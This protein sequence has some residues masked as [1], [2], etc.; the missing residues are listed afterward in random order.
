M[1]QHVLDAT[2]CYLA[3]GLVAGLFKG[4][5]LGKEWPLK[6][7]GSLAGDIKTLWRTEPDAT[8]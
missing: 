1:I 5:K 2:T 7:F 4:R 8:G 6:A 3:S